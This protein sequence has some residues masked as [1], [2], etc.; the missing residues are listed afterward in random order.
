MHMSQ[1][2]VSHILKDSE[3]QKLKEI[4]SA[5]GILADITSLSTLLAKIDGLREGAVPIVIGLWLMTRDL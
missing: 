5:S 1:E 4:F 3:G 2:M